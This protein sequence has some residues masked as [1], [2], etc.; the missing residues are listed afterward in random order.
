MTVEP[1]RVTIGNRT[2]ISF[3][4]DI[5]GTPTDADSLELVARS[6]REVL[7]PYVEGTDAEIVRDSAGRYHADLIP[8]RLGLY[9]YRWAAF[10]ASGDPLAAEEGSFR[11]VSLVVPA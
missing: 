8:T 4:I 2:R 10:D 1:L 3:A 5:D 9:R 7:G 6:G 11:V